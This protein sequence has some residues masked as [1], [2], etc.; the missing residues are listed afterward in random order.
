[1]RWIGCVHAHELFGDVSLLTGIPCIKGITPILQVMRA[2]LRDDEDGETKIYLI[3]A[4]KTEQDILCRQ[5]IDNFVTKNR[6]RLSVYYILSSTATLTEGW[7]QGRGHVDE[8]TLR[9]YLPDPSHEGRNAGSIE[10]CGLEDKGQMILGCGPSS[11][12][13]SMKVALNSIGWD[14]ER[15]VVVF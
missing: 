6:H 7:T 9:R 13:D 14:V 11:M 2:I 3:Y 5:E 15:D 12:I 10:G 4:N 8:G 1:M